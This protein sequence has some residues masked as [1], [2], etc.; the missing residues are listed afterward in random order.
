MIS[1]RRHSKLFVAFVIF[2]IVSFAFVSTSQAILWWI[3]GAVRA[4]VV[5]V[6]AFLSTPQGQ[7]IARSCINHAIVLGGVAYLYFDRGSTPPASERY[8]QVTLTGAQAVVKG[9]IASG[10]VTTI[11]TPSGGW[12]T[13][14][15]QT[16]IPSVGACCQSTCPGQTR[17]LIK[18]ST[19][20][21]SLSCLQDLS[22]NFAGYGTSVLQDTCVYQNG[23]TNTI[24]YGYI[25]ICTAAQKTAWLTSGG[26]ITAAAAKVMSDSVVGPA[27]RAAV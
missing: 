9:A 13:S 7:A 19:P 4:G 17:A 14:I 5:T 18:S 25:A 10:A 1:S 24:T 15:T 3:A 16:Y 20:A 12:G 26:N 2:L 21:G 6:G 22:F 23:A 27:F 8:I 11:G